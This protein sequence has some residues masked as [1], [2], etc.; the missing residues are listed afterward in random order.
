MYFTKHPNL[1]WL[2]QIFHSTCQKRGSQQ[3]FHKLSSNKMEPIVVAPEA[4]LQKVA[5]CWWM[6]SHLSITLCSLGI[7]HNS[8]LNFQSHTKC[9][10]KLTFFHFKNISNL[11]RLQQNR[12]Q[13]VFSAAIKSSQVHKIMGEAHLNPHQHSLLPVKICAI[14]KASCP[15]TR[16]SLVFVFGTTDI[17][18][19]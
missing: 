14:Q 2:R 9:I 18:S 13:Y 7:T 5:G 11:S 4:L 1:Q 8:S 16:A 15:S 17:L 6:L 19:P 12:H 3:N 10:T